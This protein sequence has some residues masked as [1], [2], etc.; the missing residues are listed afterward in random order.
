MKEKIKRLAKDRKFQIGVAVG[1]GTAYLI[2]YSS[3]SSN[4]RRGYMTVKPIGFDDKG[5]WLFESLS[6]E[7]FGVETSV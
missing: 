7:I 3:A 5:Q 4:A 2:G 6:G 1:F